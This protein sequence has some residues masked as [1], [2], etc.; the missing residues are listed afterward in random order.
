MIPLVQQ[1]QTSNLNKIIMDIDHLL[2]LS[3]THATEARKDGNDPFGAL[4]VD[5]NHEIVS[6]ARNTVLDDGSSIYHAEI[7]AIEEAE[8]RRGESLKGCTIVSSAEPCPMCASAIIWSGI[9]QVIFGVS[10]E[11]LIRND[12]HQI[13]ISCRNIFDE[14]DRRIIV[15]GPR[16]Q[17]EGLEVFS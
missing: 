14:A 8:S 5:E 9:E 1:I 6:A 12:I 15:N 17:E 16:L 13:D 11:K 10:I 7:N 2:R 4:V 3:F